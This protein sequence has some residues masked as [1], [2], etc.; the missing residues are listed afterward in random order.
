M[1][2]I[3]KAVLKPHEFRE[4]V[5][6]LRD[7]AV[8]YAGAQSLREGIAHTLSKYVTHTPHVPV[9]SGDEL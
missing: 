6:D 8:K 4:L 2:S 3:E 1:M 7:T 9:P 5:N